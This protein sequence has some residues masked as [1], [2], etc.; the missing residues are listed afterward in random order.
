MC[1]DLDSSPPIPTIAGAAVEHEDLVLEAADGTRFGAF[2]ARP[3]EPSGIGVAILPDVRGLYRFYEELALRF[4]ERGVLAIAFD[5]FGRTAGVEKRPD[6][7]DYSGHVAQTTSATVQADVRAVVERLRAEGAGAV[8][9]VGFCFGGGHSW[10]AAASG[11]GLAGA[12]G[13]YGRPGE[14]NGEPGALQ[15]AG[16]IE[17]PIL[18][19]QAGADPHITAEDNAAFERALARAGVEHEIVAFEGA[20]H[21]FFDRKQEEFADASDDAW[22]RVLAFLE[23]Y[24]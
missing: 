17:A 16:E 19:L 3:D 7:W 20:P 23:R 15:R 21:S 22:A 5:Y 1:F 2:L 18:A 4:A 8:F 10:L 11:H 12:V 9:T 6:D 24:R 13:F 14:R